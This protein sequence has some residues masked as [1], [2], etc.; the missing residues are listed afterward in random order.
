MRIYE[1]QG[2]CDIFP[3][4]V[5]TCNPIRQQSRAKT[6]SKAHY[7][8]MERRIF[9]RLHKLYKVPVENVRRHFEWKIVLQVHVYAQKK[10]HKL[11]QLLLEYVQ[12]SYTDMSDDIQ[13]IF[14]NVLVF[15]NMINISILYSVMISLRNNIK[16]L[17][18][19]T[20]QSGLIQH[21]NFLFFA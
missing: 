3:A 13:E 18:I 8:T 1:H 17:Y 14:S 16:Y 19:K 2:D 20:V 21:Y 15:I 12:A 11:F 7:Q 9:S 10:L 4:Q 5:S 6:R